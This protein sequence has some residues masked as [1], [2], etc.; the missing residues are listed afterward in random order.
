VGSGEPDFPR[1]TDLRVQLC[2][3][4]GFGSTHEL[5]W[6]VLEIASGLSWWRSAKDKTLSQLAHSRPDLPHS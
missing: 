3:N 2:Q 6:V 5:D 1:L 4:G